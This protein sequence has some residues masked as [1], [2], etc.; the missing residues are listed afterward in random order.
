[1]SMFIILLVLGCGI[2]LAALAA[3]IYVL[4]TQREQE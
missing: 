4:L 2:M 3:L 1:M